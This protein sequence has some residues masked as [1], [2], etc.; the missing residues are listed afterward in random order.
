MNAPR[1]ARQADVLTA[2]GLALMESK[3]LDGALAAFDEAVRLLPDAERFAHRGD[4]HFS[5]KE[6][7]RAEA[8]YCAA[9]ELAQDVASYLFRR[10][11]LYCEVDR[12]DEALRDLNEAIRLDPEPAEAY[13]WR[14]LTI[15]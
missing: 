2:R 9:I 7:N 14:G 13:Y 8:D 11:R 15:S 12:Y 6:F 10:G 3:D 5:R 1:D 4:C